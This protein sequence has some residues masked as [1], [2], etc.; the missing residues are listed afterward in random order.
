MPVKSLC[1]ATQTYRFLTI[2]GDSNENWLALSERFDLDL[3]RY[4]KPVHD[5]Q[6]DIQKNYIRPSRFKTDATSCAW[7]TRATVIR[8]ATY[9]CGLL[10]WRLGLDMKTKWRSAASPPSGNSG[11]GIFS[12]A[13]L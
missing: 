6:A 12:T 11:F 8:P 5:G 10:D 2:A 4:F 9:A 7:S 1:Q 3:L 13:C